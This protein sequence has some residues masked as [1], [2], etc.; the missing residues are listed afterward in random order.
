M[1][2]DRCLPGDRS[3]SRTRSGAF[4]V[5][6]TGSRPQLTDQSGR[7]D[8][9]SSELYFQGGSLKAAGGSGAP[10]TEVTM[11]VAMSRS[12]RLRV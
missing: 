10:P 8:G 3:N 2:R 6:S 7:D 11:S 1:N 4:P 5:P 9:S 12:L